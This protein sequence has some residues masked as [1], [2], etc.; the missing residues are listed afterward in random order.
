MNNN[1][2][3]WQK[4][5]EMQPEIWLRWPGG[6]KPK[7]SKHGGEEVE[8]DKNGKR[9]EKVLMNISMKWIKR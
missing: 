5:F 3:K 8:K 2:Q 7:S 4:V 9:E 1:Q 6:Q